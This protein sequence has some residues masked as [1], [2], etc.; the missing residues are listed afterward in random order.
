MGVASHGGC[1]LCLMQLVG[2]VTESP[3]FMFGIEGCD[4]LQ[5]R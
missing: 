3:G 4:V 5:V 2:V 1:G